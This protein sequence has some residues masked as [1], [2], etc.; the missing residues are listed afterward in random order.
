[1]IGL[2]TLNPIMYNYGGFLQELALQDALIKM[3]YN[4]EIINY[5]PAEELN[6]FSAKRGI[7]YFTFDKFLA[8]LNPRKENKMK[9]KIYKNK[10]LI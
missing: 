6:T 2:L 9:G 5:N 3:G 10:R 1:M 7:K 4:I 8:M